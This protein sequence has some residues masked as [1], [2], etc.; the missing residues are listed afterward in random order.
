RRCGREPFGVQLRR[1]QSE[2]IGNCLRMPAGSRQSVLPPI[3]ARINE[4]HRTLP[5]IGENCC[6]QR[7]TISR[8]GVEV[9]AVLTNIW[10]AGPQR[11]MA[12][13]NDS[14]ELHI[15]GKERLPDP[16]EIVRILVTEGPNRVNAGMDEKA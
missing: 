9:Y 6:C 8:T 1:D 13:N 7:S 5:V 15:R 14:V 4:L 16:K 3:S 11:G 10:L 2:L 12:V